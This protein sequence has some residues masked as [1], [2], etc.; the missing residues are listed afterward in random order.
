MNDVVLQISKKGILL[1]FKGRLE[2][3]LP[4]SADAVLGRNIY[5]I[6][7]PDIVQSVMQCVEK[8][9]H[10]GDVQG[11]EYLS[12]TNG[13][14]YELK[15]IVSGED[16]VFAF[17]SNISDYR[18]AAE[19][20]RYLAHHDT[21]TNLPN[22]YLFNDRLK[23]AIAH[24]ERGKKLMAILFLDL[25]NFKQINDTIGHRAGDQLLQIVADR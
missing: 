1:D 7:P 15:F 9:L 17:V 16:R 23:Q 14:Y 11:C 20:V 25:D 22:R 2:T 21:L 5:D 18:Q 10:T 4:T 24:A 6:M 3:F 19:K 8:A 13:Q 12:P